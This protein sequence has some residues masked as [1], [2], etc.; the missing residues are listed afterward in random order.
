MMLSAPPVVVML[1][2][3][4]LLVLQLLARGYTPGQIALFTGSDDRAVSDA[5]A[6]AVWALDAADAI[7][8]V[9]VARSRGLIL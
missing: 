2:G 8:A 4:E 3:R 9:V 6:G 1:T 7:Q 5:L